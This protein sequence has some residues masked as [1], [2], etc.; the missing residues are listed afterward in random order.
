[1]IKHKL[2]VETFCSVIRLNFV[3]MKVT[4]D[5]D[6]GDISIGSLFLNAKLLKDGSLRNRLTYLPPP[7][8]S[9][10]SKP[11]HTCGLHLCFGEENPTYERT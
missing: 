9:T 4:E 11:R 5:F 3:V 8:P 6:G 2:C 1:M 7:A 10:L